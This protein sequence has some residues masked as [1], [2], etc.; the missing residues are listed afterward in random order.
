[1]QKNKICIIGG[2][3]FVGSYITRLFA[4][5]GRPVRVLTSRRDHA[6]ALFVLPSVDIIE[7]NIH[8]ETQLT[9]ALAGCDAVINLVGVLHDSGRPGQGF[10]RAHVDLTRKVI[11]A[12]KANNIQR[13]LHMSALKAD[14]NG[15]SAYL[16]SKG[17]AEQLVRES[18]LQWTIFC[19][20][21]IFGRGDSFLN[22]FAALLAVAPVFP[23]AG[24]D[25][26]FQPVWVE[27]VARAFVGS[28][29][30]RATFGKRY[31]LCGPQIYTLRELVQLVAHIKGLKRFV[32][33]LPGPVAYM[34]A[35]A[36]EILPG[37]MMSRDN[38]LSMKVDNV[39]GCDFPAEF[40]FAP[41]A[42]ESVAPQFIAQIDLISRFNR[43]RAGAGR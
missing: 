29:D 15:P 39:C 40:G 17:Q 10:Q 30:N 31:N 19:P 12:C 1:M 43:Y 8:D 36:L 41:A 16:R 4:G 21:V 18:G 9:R 32:I 23:L 6:K 42:L 20:S 34:Q 14:V 38:L 25:A 22:L 7:A 11:A 28:V 13:L 26:K 3:G 2:S 35:L 33:G 27:D 37:K 24:A 5:Q